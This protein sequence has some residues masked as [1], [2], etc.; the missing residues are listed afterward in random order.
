MR[1]CNYLSSQLSLPPSPSPSLS[2]S[3]QDGDAGG[4]EGEGITGKVRDDRSRRECLRE[5]G[6]EKCM[7]LFGSFTV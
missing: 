4:R 2:S 7:L 1:P 3:L 5:R 6:A